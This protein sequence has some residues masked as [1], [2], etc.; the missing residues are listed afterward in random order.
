[1]EALVAVADAGDI[2]GRPTAIRIRKTS[3]LIRTQQRMMSSLLKN[4]ERGEYHG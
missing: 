1:M 3:R 4:E 2:M